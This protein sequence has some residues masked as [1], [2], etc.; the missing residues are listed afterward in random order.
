MT[1]MYL[2]NVIEYDPHAEDAHSQR[3]FVSATEFDRN[4][5]QLVEGAADIKTVVFPNTI[6]EISEDAFSDTSV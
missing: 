6:R 2:N 3:L 5:S 1:F 4:M